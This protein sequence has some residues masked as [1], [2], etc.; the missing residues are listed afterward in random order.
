MRSNEKLLEKNAADGNLPIDML[1]CVPPGDQ[2]Q[3][4]QGKSRSNLARNLSEW[5]H[6]VWDGTDL[7]VRRSAPIRV[8]QHRVVQYDSCRGLEG[9]IVVNYALDDFLT[10]KFESIPLT[11]ADGMLFEDERTRRYR[12]DE[13]TPGLVRETSAQLYRP[14]TRRLETPG[15]RMLLR[16]KPTAS[17]VSFNRMPS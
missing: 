9:W 6:D 11:S 13:L 5:G 10:Y 8:S 1:F 14:L 3:G 12:F 15:R 17:W 7:E 4:E 16:T 2:V